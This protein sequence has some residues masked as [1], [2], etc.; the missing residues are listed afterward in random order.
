MDS[1]DELAMTHKFVSNNGFFFP[2]NDLKTHM[3]WGGELQQLPLWSTESSVRP[4]EQQLEPSRGVSLPPACL[5]HTAFYKK[6][7]QEN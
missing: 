2:L 7:E 6:N 3:P 1:V 5:A 4:T